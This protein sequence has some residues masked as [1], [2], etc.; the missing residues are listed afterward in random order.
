VQHVLN[1]LAP[2]LETAQR[3][4]LLKLSDAYNKESK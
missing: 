1:L 4:H 2:Y 3:D